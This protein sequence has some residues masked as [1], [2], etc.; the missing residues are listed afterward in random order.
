[1]NAFNPAL[2]EILSRKV[3]GIADEMALTLKRT[4]RSAFVKEGGDFGVGVADLAGNIFAWPSDS[5][6]SGVSTIY[7]PLHGVIEAFPD[8]EP[9][10]VIGTND[11]YTSD[12][13]STHLPDYHLVRPYFHAGRI[14]AYGWCF[15]H[16]NDVGGRVPGSVSP[17]NTDIFQEGLRVP[18]L[19]I[20]RGG[21]V[22]DDWLALFTANSRSPELNLG[23]FKALLAALETGAKRVQRMIARHGADAFTDCQD[24]LLAYAEEKTRAVLSMRGEDPGGARRGLR[25]LGLRRRRHDHAVSVPHPARGHV[26]RRR[27]DHRLERHRP[28]GAECAQLPLHGAHVRGLH[29]TPGHIHLHPRQDHP[30]QRRDLPP[31]CRDQPAGTRHE[32]R[33]PERHRL[34][35]RHH[36]APERR[37]ERHF[38]TGGARADGGALRRRQPRGDL[39]RARD[40]RAQPKPDHR[41]PVHARRHGGRT[42]AATGSTAATSRT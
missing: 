38:V 42:A 21:A 10:D 7:Y 27:G 18:P 37:V 8:L 5:T 1:M 25:V 39:F 23:D 4:A 6:V 41:G 40:G 3:S 32:R 33:V 11:A 16:F 15:C 9:G 19:K 35:A 28:A 14:V 29:P 17:T 26:S 36:P 13:L 22:N 24:A 2:L 20:V 31:H 30:V 12:G 34:A